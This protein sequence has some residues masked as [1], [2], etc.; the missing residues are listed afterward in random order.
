MVV[1]ANGNVFSDRT[2]SHDLL[3]VF[4]KPRLVPFANL[5]Q[6]VGRAGVHHVSGHYLHN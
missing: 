1:V 3:H 5:I 2:G 6:F 4:E